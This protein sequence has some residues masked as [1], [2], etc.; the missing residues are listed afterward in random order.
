M[1]F[2]TKF[3][4]ERRDYLAI[5]N[6]DGITSKDIWNETEFTCE[7][8]EFIFKVFFTSSAVIN[9]V[10]ASFAFEV[11]SVKE[12]AIVTFITRPELIDLNFFILR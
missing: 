12:E 9:K 8:S 2:S 3:I 7:T 4:R 10:L 11:S 1:A 5:W 6:L